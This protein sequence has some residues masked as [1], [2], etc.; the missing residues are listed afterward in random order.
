LY[1]LKVKK[2]QFVRLA[3]FIGLAAIIKRILLQEAHGVRTLWE[4]VSA[5]HV[6]ESPFN[7]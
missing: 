1:N 2:I 4:N 6:M 7:N 3:L 5:R